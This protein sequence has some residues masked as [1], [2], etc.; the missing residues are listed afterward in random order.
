MHPRNTLNTAG[1]MLTCGS[2]ACQLFICCQLK[3][4]MVRRPLLR[5]KPRATFS[6]C[7]YQPS[8][9]PTA[10]KAIGH[11]C[12]C[13]CRTL[14]SCKTQVTRPFRPCTASQSVVRRRY[15]H[16]H[17]VHKWQVLHQGNRPYGTH[18]ELSRQICP[19][20]HRECP[21]R[22]TNVFDCRT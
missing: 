16:G 9:S 11:C 7:Q 5:S 20:A 15:T 12:M 3:P 8:S 22:C 1:V 17:R 21:A 6:P 14:K 19:M 4:E 2:W 13:K 10:G 18:M